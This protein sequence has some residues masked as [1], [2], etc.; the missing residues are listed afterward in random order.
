MSDGTGVIASIEAQQREETGI[1]KLKVRLTTGCS[2][3]I[4]RCPTPYRDQVP[5][6]YIRKQTLANCERYI[7]QELKELE[8][9]DPGRQGPASWRW[10]TSC[11]AQLREQIAGQQ[12]AAGAGHRQGAMAAAG[13][14]LLLCRR[15]R[16]SNSYCRPQVERPDDISRSRTAATR[17]WSR[18]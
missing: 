4:L 15:W 9:T 8:S 10:N 5:E 2:V 13:C 11:S 17:W 3:T 18:C 16:P 6:T 14:A 1:P 7:T 12:S